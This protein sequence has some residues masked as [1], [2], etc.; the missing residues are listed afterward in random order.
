M[1]GFWSPITACRA[2]MTVP[3]DSPLLESAMLALRCLVKLIVSQTIFRG[4][5]VEC[6]VRPRTLQTQLKGARAEFKD[7]QIQF[8]KRA[9]NLPSTILMMTVS[10]L[11]HL[12]SSS[13]AM[14]SSRSQAIMKL[15][16]L[17]V[18]TLDSL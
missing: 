14:A 7:L 2:V 18:A 10:I 16:V 4:R 5:F 11:W 6:N 13:T 1:K 12:S 17:A 8:E 3:A 15:N 9:K